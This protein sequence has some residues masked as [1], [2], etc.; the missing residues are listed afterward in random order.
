DQMNSLV[1]H[2]AVGAVFIYSVDRFARR[3]ED[4]LRL[5]REYKKHGTRLDFVEMPF[6]DTPVGRFTFTQLA[7][8]AELWGEKIL[9]DSARGRKQKLESG[10]LDHGGAKYGYVYIDKR[11]KDG[12]RLELD[13]REALPGLTR[14]QVV[15]DIF[16]W[17]LE[18]M[19]MYGIARRL[20]EAGILSAGYNG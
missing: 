5:A 10:K 18:G 4:A 13:T 19:S 17:R 20:N 12:A 16:R 15:K 14:V 11:Q 7:A 1:A 8:F 2:G 9:A 3:T 6:E